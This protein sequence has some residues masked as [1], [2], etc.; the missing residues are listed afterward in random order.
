MI[1]LDGA[2][3]R[4]S[5]AW[6]TLDSVDARSLLASETESTIV[7]ARGPTVRNPWNLARNTR[8][9][10]RTLRATRP[11]AIVTTGTALAVPFAWLGRLT[12]ARVVYVEC[13]GRADRPSLACRLV[14]PIASRIYV[15]WPALLRKLPRARYAGRVQLRDKHLRGL[16]TSD[17]GAA[18]T[19]FATVG[20][21]P[22]QFD[23]LVAAVD[24]LSGVPVVVQVGYSSASTQHARRVTF[25][26][27]DQLVAHMRSA[28]VVVTHAG[29]GSVLLARAC[30][31]RPIVL[32]RR[33]E[34]GENVDDH[35]LGFAAAMASE[36]MITLV[37]DARQL[38]RAVARGVENPALVTPQPQHDRLSAE[39]QAYLE[40]AVLGRR[41]GRTRPLGNA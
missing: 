26:P 41:A 23:R 9:A 17:P 19:V 38:A 7:F 25:V 21:C 13:G 4:F 2:W 18:A 22:F 6:V 32:A 27:F 31:K 8:L 33:P 11:A 3:S 16:D 14:A 29:I 5:R 15:Q 40:T 12:G 30:G 1:G 28:R 37:G 20:T 10:W 36:G 34:L 39:L 24:G 35:Q